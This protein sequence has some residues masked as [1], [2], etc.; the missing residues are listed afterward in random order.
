MNKDEMIKNKI[1]AA[2]KEIVDAYGTDKLTISRICEKCSISRSTFYKYF[3]T[4]EELIDHLS[5]KPHIPVQN[6]R[7]MRDLILFTAVE[8]ISK[9]GF[10]NVS[11]NDIAKEI[12]INR[13]SLYSYFSSISEIAKSIIA[14]EFESREEL[15]RNTAASKLDPLIK[16]ERYLDYHMN[17]LSKKNNQ[18]LI[19]DMLE[20]YY[21]N[22]AIREGF[23]SIE[24]QSIQHIAKV[25]EDGK[26]DNILL[27]EVDSKQYATLSYIFGYG[28]AMYSYLHQECDIKDQLKQ[29][30]LNFLLDGIIKK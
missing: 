17:L 15:E 1:L 4:K 29:P 10:D 8:L 18:R 16:I 30:V 20:G 11:M 12:G 24:A 23:E 13:T 7:C 28:L 5:Q 26:R 22:D 9:K 2:S 25:I 6:I 21:K 3:S 19:I 14:L 27:P